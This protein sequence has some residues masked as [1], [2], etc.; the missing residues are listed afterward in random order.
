MM[1][2]HAI[3]GHDVASFDIPSS[4][5]ELTELLWLIMAVFVLTKVCF[6]SDRLPTVPASQALEE[7]KASPAAHISTGLEPLD[8]ALLGLDST[9]SQ[10][11][12]VHGGIKRGQVT[13]I[14]GPPGCG[15]TA[16]G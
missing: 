10:D 14:W 7:L 2:Y 1:D 9:D 11:A 3:H 8:S 4:T 6:L 16:V 5:R 15:K 13:E 12:V